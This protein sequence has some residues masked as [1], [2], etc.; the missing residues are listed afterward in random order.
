MLAWLDIYRA[1]FRVA[2]A[3]QLQYRVSLVIWLIGMV[4]EPVMYLVVWSTV[5]RAQGGAVGG[6]DVRDFAAYFITTMLVNHWT[7][8]WIMHDFEYMVRMGQ[9]S[10]QL[11]RP[12]H[13][14]HFHMAD[15]ITY[16]L[17][18]STVMLPVAAILA[19]AFQPRW[20][21]EPWAV[22]AFVP[23]F[24]LSFGVRFLLGCTLAL[25]AFWTTRVFAINEMY[26]VA[27]LFLSGQMA[28]LALLPGAAQVVASVLPFRWVV[29]FP[30]ELI[31]GRVEPE[32]ALFGLGVELCWLIVSYVALNALWGAGV[33]RYSAVGA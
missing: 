12:L 19:L 23:A 7:F 21:P 31:L 18:T 13:P 10:P 32:Q 2:F 14:L 1:Q 27:S 29:G 3:I 11:L 20:A 6:F 8:T 4:L 9:L 5:A 22:L 25:A 30:V 15:N 16:K 28:P 33:R 24:L 26:F 17:L